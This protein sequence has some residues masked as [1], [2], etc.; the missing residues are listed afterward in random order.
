MGHKKIEKL[1]PII[2]L[3]L[4]PLI[5]V[6]CTPTTIS[7]TLNGEQQEISEAKSALET[8]DGKLILGIVENTG[9]PPPT[10]DADSNYK[11][12]LVFNPSSLMELEIG[13]AYTIRGSSEVDLPGYIGNSM[14]ERTLINV[15]DY[16]PD[17]DQVSALTT[18]WMEFSCG[19]CVAPVFDEVKSQSVDGSITFSEIS[20]NRLAGELTLTVEGAIPPLRED[21]YS[22]ELSAH[23]DAIPFLGILGLL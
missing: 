3:A 5:L 12:Y 8:K 20:E 9:L 23:F 18:A 21:D 11:T 1:Q 7:L 6:S 16:T 10:I 2:F 4:A 17:A 13:V 14:G 22:A 15:V 19:F